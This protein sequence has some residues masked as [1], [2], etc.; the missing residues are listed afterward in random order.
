M[1]IKK[2]SRALEDALTSVIQLKQIN[3]LSAEGGGGCGAIPSC[4]P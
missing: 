1:Q 4:F 2:F 3:H